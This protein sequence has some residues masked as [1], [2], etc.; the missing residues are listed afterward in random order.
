M[1]AAP[2]RT[3]PMLLRAIATALPMLLV[4]RLAAG[5][6]DA[7][8]TGFP[9]QATVLSLA[10]EPS[11][12]TVYAGTDHGLF[13]SAD[14]G[15]SWLLIQSLPPASPIW[16]IAFDT[17]HG[18]IYVGSHGAADVFRSDDGGST[19][20]AFSFGGGLSAFP[21]SLGVDPSGSGTVYAG[22]Q[23]TAGPGPGLVKSVDRGK[24]WTS[25]TAG[26]PLSVGIP[27]V[28]SIAVDPTAPATVYV[29]LDNFGVY[30]SV[31]AGEH[32]HLAGLQSFFPQISVEAL[33][34][35]PGSPSTLYAAT[36]V[37][38]FRSADAA[39]SWQEM[40]S[41]VYSVPVHALA[42]D[43][44]NTDAVFAATETAGVFRTTDGAQTWTRW[45]D[46]LPSPRVSTLAIDPR[47]AAV[48]AGTDTA[49][50]DRNAAAPPE[51]VLVHPPR[52]RPMP[53]VVGFPPQ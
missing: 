7:W 21:K 35:V 22:L 46:G 26:L 31:D 16:S 17:V 12:S 42:V 52:R 49:V 28:L 41:G 13:H 37:G 4:A 50:F 45:D 25:K 47:G 40:D 30:K 36:N 11:S 2:A 6:D 23:A 1:A 33:A 29:G 15:K 32:W 8:T 10:V 18:S 51:R 14:G 5:G 34:T 20:S 53:R 48:H 3:F 9:V 38:I 39:G 27:T 19:W 43:P 24:T 44:A